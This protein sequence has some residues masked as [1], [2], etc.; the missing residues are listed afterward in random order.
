MMELV[1]FGA[2]VLAGGGALLGLTRMKGAQ[3]PRCAIRDAADGNVVRIV[4][5]VERDHEILTAPLSGVEALTYDVRV[6][7][8]WNGYR[9]ILHHESKCVPFLL[10]DGT[11]ELRIDPCS[12]KIEL[13][14]HRT[15]H[16][17]FLE[18]L[19][20]RQNEFLQSRHL[21]DTTLFG[22]DLPLYL[23]ERTLQEGETIAVIG[24]ARWECDPSGQLQGEPGYRDT[25]KRLR[26]IAPLDTSVLLSARSTRVGD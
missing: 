10:H 5:E 6:H 26:I 20:E 8:E 23:S 18:P 14:E 11:G 7:E 3:P 12:A 16:R 21:R 1:V 15:Y 19:D 25:A 13:E 24:M 9:T 2:I 22:F 17:G 4:G